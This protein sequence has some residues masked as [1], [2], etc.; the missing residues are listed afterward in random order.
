MGMVALRRLELEGKKKTNGFFQ[1][2]DIPERKD[3]RIDF[4][5]EIGNI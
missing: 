1:M 3:A 4:E 2:Y 5:G